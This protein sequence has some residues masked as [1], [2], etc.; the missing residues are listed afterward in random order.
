VTTYLIMWRKTTPVGP[1]RD[2]TRATTW[3]EALRVIKTLESIGAE[4]TGLVFQ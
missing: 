4:V 1:Q 3:P 2:A